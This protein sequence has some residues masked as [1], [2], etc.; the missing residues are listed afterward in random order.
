V[1]EQG[2]EDDVAIT[3]VVAWF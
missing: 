2:Y 1:R 3:S